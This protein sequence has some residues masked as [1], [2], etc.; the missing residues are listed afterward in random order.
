MPMTACS[1]PTPVFTEFHSGPLKP[2]CGNCLHEAKRRIFKEFFDVVGH[3]GHSR[4]HDIASGGLLNEMCSGPRQFDIVEEG[5]DDFVVE[6]DEAGDRRHL[7]HR[8]VVGP[9]DI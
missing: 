2:G 3:N 5:V 1:A 7:G 4:T 6:G 8:V 9:S